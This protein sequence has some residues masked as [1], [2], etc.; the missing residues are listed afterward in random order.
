M[1][2][3]TGN[4][5][6]RGILKSPSVKKNAI[7]NLGSQVLVGLLSMAALPWL[8]KELGPESYAIAALFVVVQ[9]WI[10]LLD[11]GL[12]QVVARETARV[13]VGAISLT[14]Y[15]GLYRAV[16]LLFLVSAAI[17]SLALAAGARWIASEWLNAEY[18]STRTL[19]V[20]IALMGLASALRWYAGLGRG[21]I[22]G[23]EHFVWLSVTNTGLAIARW[24]LVVPVLMLIEP[25]APLIAYMQYQVVLSCLE[26]LLI[27][28]KARTLTGTLDPRSS[29]SGIEQDWGAVRRR[30]PFA[31]SLALSSAVWVLVTQ[32]DR[33][34]LS[35]VLPL[36]SYAIFSIAVTLA[37][38]IVMVFSP[39]GAVILP[40]LTQLAAGGDPRL[41]ANSY[42]RF[43]R[44]VALVVFPIGFTLTAVS[45]EILRV[46][47]GDNSMSAAAAPITSVYSLGNMALS[48]S[49]FGFYLQFAVGRLRLHVLASVFMAL[50]LVPMQ[51]AFA[52]RW[53]GEG[54]A[55]VWASV[56]LLYLM[57]WMPI[58]H[59]VHLRGA[60]RQW[61]FHGVLVPGL[62]VGA[63]VCI[64]TVIIQSVAP[65]PDAMAIG[66]TFLIAVLA[67]A[68]WWQIRP[69]LKQVPP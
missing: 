62:V 37:G 51:V 11:L 4:R 55:A 21:V 48:M 12:G 24:V 15:L 53:G 8:V 34:T 38:V 67:S 28:G 23:H 27:R 69:Q 7:A 49:A 19:T 33:L 68:A 57:G 39:L 44:A 43:T 22:S 3:V 52:I 59:R 36:A 2:S 66:A 20:A 10:S 63:P 54:A 31:L 30:M 40:W 50:I 56:N 46:W 35:G 65:L 64:A 16:R 60:H 1:L 47:T 45:E 29:Q 25:S 14:E 61:F 13:R 18:L 6:S 5:V 9:T 41:L 26:V 17:A 32:S 42:I 58:V